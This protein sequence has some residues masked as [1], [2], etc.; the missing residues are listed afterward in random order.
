MS[1]TMIKIYALFLC[2]FVFITGARAELVEITPSE[3]YS[4][5]M[6]IDKEIELLKKHF[7]MHREKKADIYRGNLRPRHVWEKS[8][9]IQVKINVLRK[10]NRFT[11]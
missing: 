10:K 11:P 8:Y 2:F 7:G 3:V 9:L 6:Q 4:Q 1:G 5:V